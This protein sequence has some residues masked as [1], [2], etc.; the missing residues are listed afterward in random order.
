MLDSKPAFDQPKPH[1]IAVSSMIDTS[2]GCPVRMPV[3]R[4]K[5]SPAAAVKFVTSS[6]SSPFLLAA[7]ALKF[8]LY[9][10]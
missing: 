2:S 6:M 7:P 1:V 9:T 10:C 4:S 8:T 3:C 5:I